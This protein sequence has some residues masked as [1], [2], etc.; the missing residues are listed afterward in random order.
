MHRSDGR[1]G[2]GGWGGVGVGVPTEQWPPSEVRSWLP[3][4]IVENK[5]HFQERNVYVKQARGPKI[6]RS[7]SMISKRG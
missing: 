1:Q 5:D 3:E 7:S 2:G 6:G 4:E